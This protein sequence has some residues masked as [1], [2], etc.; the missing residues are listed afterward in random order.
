VGTATLQA[1]I[2]P[3]ALLDESPKRTLTLTADGPDNPL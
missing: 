1:Q 2:Q 3:V